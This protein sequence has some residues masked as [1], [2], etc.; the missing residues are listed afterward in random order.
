MPRPVTLFT[1]QWADLPLD[2]VCVLASRWGFDGLELACWGDH[3]EIDRALAEDDYCANKRAQLERHGLQCWTI[4]NHLVGQAICD[5]PIDERHRAIVPD[6]VW[7]DGDPEGVR[8]RAADDM[9]DAARAAQKFGVD[10]VVGFSGSSIW[11]TLAGFPPVPEDMLDAGYDDFANRFN[12]IIDVFDECGVRFALEVH[13][14]EIAYD[15]WTTK[16]TLDAIGYRPGFGIN[17]DPSHMVWQFLDPAMFLTE[18]A[19]RIYRVHCKGVARNLD[20]RNGVLS[21]H[22]GFGDP[23]RGWDFVSAGH[24]D[25]PWERIIRTLNAIGYDG[26]LS[27]EWEDA[28]MDREHGAAEALEFIRKLDFPTPEARFDAAFSSD[29]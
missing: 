19:D 28:G 5:V 13:P 2:H 16:R 22:L 24:D 6:R 8:Q 14:S 29:R 27:I 9:R 18:F 3:F 20:G 15:F 1:G 12:P 4:S 23:R 10:T 17:F 7:G 25:V 26:P 21:S 11:H